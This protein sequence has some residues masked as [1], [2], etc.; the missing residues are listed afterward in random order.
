MI[1]FNMSAVYKT[2]CKTFLIAQKL[3]GQFSNVSSINDSLKP[4]Y[5]LRVVKEYRT[6][7]MQHFRD[8]VAKIARYKNSLN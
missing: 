1:I 7:T 4:P 5:C 6:A 3:A 8:S 2:Q